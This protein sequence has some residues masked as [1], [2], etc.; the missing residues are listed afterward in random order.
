MRRFRVRL[1]E[2]EIAG[3]SFGDPVKPVQ[4]LFLHA[5]GFNA[6]TYQSI[7][8]PLGARGHVAAAD[9]R[10]HGRTTLPADPPKMSGWNT[11]RDDI[12]ALLDEIA[13]QGCVLAGH[14][15]GGVTAMLV[16]AKRPD[17]AKAVVA[18]DPVL[19]PPT[20]YAYAHM[21][22]MVGML[23]SNFDLAKG[24]RRRREVFS[25]PQE[26]EAALS[27]RGA[28]KTWREPFLA[29]FT[30]DGFIG[31][32]EGGQYRLACAPAWEA[33]N[34]GAQ[35]HRPW[36]AI[37]RMKCPL[38][39][40]RGERQSTVAPAQE[41]LILRKKPDA[42]VITVPG[43]SHFIPMERPY[44]VRDAMSELFARLGEANVPQDEV[45]LRRNLRSDAL[46]D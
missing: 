14:S 12:I 17:L 40:L 9:L 38:V 18:V 4:C 37:K 41:A 3:I 5:N 21:P 43:T 34:F 39:V 35:R 44:V 26:A 10:G 19:L 8:E 22:G 25:T 1:A 42:R 32:M 15:L 29:D 31:P 28:F 13:P 27:G 16:A 2:G 36:A 11:H 20:A 7:L 6:I 46:P 45:R 23:K 30:V 33:A 24:A